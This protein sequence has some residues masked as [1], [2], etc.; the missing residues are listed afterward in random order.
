M[1]S[2]SNETFDKLVLEASVKRPI[3]LDMW[4]EW[5]GPC[6]VFSPTYEKVSEDYSDSMDFYKLNI[7]ENPELAD[8]YGIKSIPTVLVFNNSEPI[9][10]VVGIIPE[11]KLRYELEYV[12]SITKN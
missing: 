12:L 9:D 1:I 4:A 8:K 10:Q 11:D 7:D 5:C 6:K 2:V 3:V